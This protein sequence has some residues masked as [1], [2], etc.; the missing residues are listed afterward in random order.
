MYMHRL[1]VHTYIYIY[2]YVIIYI[3]TYRERERETYVYI[4]IY[5]YIYIHIHTYMYIC[6]YVCT[7]VCYLAVYCEGFIV[8]TMG[9]EARGLKRPEQAARSAKRGVPSLGAGKHLETIR[10]T[11]K[12]ASLKS[13]IV[14]VEGLFPA[15]C[16]EEV[17]FSHRWRGERTARAL[18][19]IYIYIYIYIYTYI[20][21]YI[22]IYT[23]VYTYVS[24]VL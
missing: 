15:A 5:T 6:V 14:S 22:Y 21:I 8:W 18:F 23:Y 16:R 12:S 9:S 20:H 11:A 24:H 19:H 4:K 17:I 1:Y 3:Y 7:P 2:M 13:L 10:R